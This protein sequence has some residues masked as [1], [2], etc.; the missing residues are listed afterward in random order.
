MPLVA[1]FVLCVAFS[2][3][4]DYYVSFWKLPVFCH[5]AD[6]STK[7]SPNNTVFLRARGGFVACQHHTRDEKYQVTTSP[8]GPSSTRCNFLDVLLVD[9]VPLTPYR[10]ATCLRHKDKTI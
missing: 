1:G 8:Q 6:T 3:A 10:F 2:C 5:L 7:R 4:P 9:R